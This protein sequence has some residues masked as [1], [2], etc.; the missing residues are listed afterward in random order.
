M[1]ADLLIELANYL[2][3]VPENRFNYATW[4]SNDWNK[5]PH[6]CGT[7]ACAL[8][9]ATQIPSFKKLGLRFTPYGNVSTSMTADGYESAGDPTEVAA[10]IFEI[11]IRDAHYLFNPY[12]N[13]LGVR[14]SPAR[15]ADHIRRFVCENSK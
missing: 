2:D 11:T 6:T 12:T 7:T 13:W 14:S 10:G 4:T 1:R 15:V 3:T 9:W 5:D 8:G